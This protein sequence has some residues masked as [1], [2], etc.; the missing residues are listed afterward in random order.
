MPKVIR[1]QRN[2]DASNFKSAVAMIKKATTKKELEKLD[3]G[4]ER[5]YNAGYLTAKELQQLDVMLMD[6]MASLESV[7]SF[8]TEDASN[9]NSFKSRITKAKSGGDLDKLFKSLDRVYKVGAVTAKEFEKL[10]LMIVSRLIALE[11]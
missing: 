9:F 4:F 8:R 10:D 2:E 6:K 7:R 5:V 3:R 1:R 11:P